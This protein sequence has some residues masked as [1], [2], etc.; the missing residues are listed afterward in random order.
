MASETTINLTSVEGVTPW[1][2]VGANK[3]T[4]EVVIGSG[5]TWSSAVV[6]LEW[7][8]CVDA[9]DD[10]SQTY[11]PA[12]QM[13]TSAKYLTNVSVTNRGYIRFKTSTGEGANDPA[14]KLLYLI[15]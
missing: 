4:C 10:R 11:S 12:I 3:L 1:I 8:T 6:D 7:V 15:S 9:T 2:P 5:Y 13:T 14:A